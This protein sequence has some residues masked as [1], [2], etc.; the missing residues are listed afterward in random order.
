MTNFLV[1]KCKMK[2]NTKVFLN[3]LLRGSNN[4]LIGPFTVAILRE[5][6]MRVFEAFSE[7][8]SDQV[9]LREK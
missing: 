4:L 8:R 6:L 5:V 9:L 1:T 3:N 2:R 7:T